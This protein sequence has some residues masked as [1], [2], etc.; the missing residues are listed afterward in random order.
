MNQ[1]QGGKRALMRCRGVRGATT[2]DENSPQAILEAT[3]ELLYI[4]LRANQI[5]AED[6]A[7]IYFT[8]TEDLNATYPALAARQLGWYDAALMCGHE[9]Q[10]PGGLEKCIRVMIHWNTTRSSKEVMHVY[11]RNARQLRPDRKSLPEIPLEEI[12]AAV[13]NID[14]N[15]LKFNPDG[16]S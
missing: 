7:S 2:A 6:V 3:R 5:E 1:A 12:A 9:M 10:V 4:M 11:L 8:T 16:S 15:T 14:F 13:Q